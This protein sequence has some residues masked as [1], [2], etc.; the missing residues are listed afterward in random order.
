MALT[1]GEG[2]FMGAERPARHVPVLVEEVR[3]WLAPAAGQVWVDATVGGGGHA[4]L[5]AEAVGPQGRVLAV[6]QD[7][8]MLA[9]ARARLAGLPVTFLPARFDRLPQ[10]LAELGLE[11]VDGLL[12]DLGFASDQM[13]DPQRGLSFRQDG[14]LDMRLDPT[15]DL[16]AEEI[17]NSWSEQELARL[18]WDYGEERYSRRIARRIVEQRRRQPLRS[19][20][21]LAELVRRCVPR[22]GGIDP[23]T[24]TFQAL[25]IAVNDELAALERLLAALPDLIR[26]GGRVGIISFHS[27][28]DRRV[29]Q[30]FRQADVW[31][32]LTRK[33]IMPT[34]EEI[35]VNPRARSARLRVAQRRDGPAAPP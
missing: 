19:T 28:E 30:A 4:R 29:K 23:A 20:A 14:P 10:L 27:L 24:R 3:S 12:A 33:P 11:R 6:D 8:A 34:E 32:V 25:R 15:A 13:E 7:P 9:L 35:R 16:T 17:V 31:E 2:E 5:L 21:E 1:E 18:L 22:S 26:P